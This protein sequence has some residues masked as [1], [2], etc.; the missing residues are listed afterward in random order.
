VLALVGLGLGIVLD[1]RRNDGVPAASRNKKELTI[2]WDR[3]S[4]P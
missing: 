3:R 2:T 4:G 1:P